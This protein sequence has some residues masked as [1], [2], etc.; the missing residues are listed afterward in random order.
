MAVQGF[1]KMILSYSLN[2]EG[3]MITDNLKRESKTDSL[4]CGFVR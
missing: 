2:N 4:L 3:C 1:C